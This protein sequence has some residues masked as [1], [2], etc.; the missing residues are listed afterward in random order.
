MNVVKNSKVDAVMGVSILLE[1]I[2]ARAQGVSSYTTKGL[3]KLCNNERM[4]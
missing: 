4:L 1:V 3:A 2:D